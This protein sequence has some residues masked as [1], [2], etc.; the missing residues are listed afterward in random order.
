MTILLPRTPSLILPQEYA[1]LLRRDLVGFVHRSFCELNPQTRFLPAPY[2]ELMAS[3]LE[4]CRLG[5]IRRLIVNLPPR[6]LK[7]H[8]VSIAFVASLLGHN[9]A[10]QIIAAS[11]GQDLADKLARDTRTVMES[12]WYTA[13]FPTRLSGRRAINDFETTA[14]GTR[15][16]TSVGG[17]L[18]G[19]GADFIIL[20]DPLKP[21]DALSEV[22]RRAVN[23]WYDNTLL[24]RL[25]DKRKGCIIIVMQRLH[26]DDLVGHVLQQ[27][28]WSVLSFPA[29][30]EEPECVPFETPY[31]PRR[32]VRQ[33]GEALH[34]NRESVQDYEAMR[35]RIGLYNFSSQYQ[36]R[37]IPISGNL[38]KREWLRY[39][40]P[41]SSPRRFLR[42]VQSW[43]TAA[44]TSELNDYSVCTTWGVGRDDYYL[45][46]VFRRRLNF[47]DLKRAIVSHAERFR[48]D[49]IVIEDK[50]SGTQLIQDLQ[51]DGVMNVVEYK[52]P[53]GADKVMRLHACSDR[54]ENGRVFLPANAPWLDEYVV[55]LV[56]FP[57]TKH[58][59]QVDS[60]TQALDY[61]RE[62][63]VVT[64]LIKAFS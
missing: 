57:G 7:S 51:N 24:S 48:A 31:G 46:D 44:K 9:P 16:A 14:G 28:D 35:R 26:Q 64:T 3:R 15:M 41:E 62:P 8:C 56:G 20:D 23:D 54:F 11:Y 1:A 42:I 58:D 18:T 53:P 32:F 43:D 61:L 4:D 63:D 55:E 38:V 22:G 47:P 33:T 27:D 36:Q 39:Y 17:V 52:P 19:R 2:I 6:S 13:L 25:N 10:A 29:I 60:T 12:D 5:K 30:A 59:D 45:I 37:P 49:D 50:S 40:T 21:T 34:P